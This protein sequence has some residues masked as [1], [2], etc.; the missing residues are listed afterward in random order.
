MVR[1]PNSM[2]RQLKGPAYCRREFIGGVPAVRISQFEHG[3][4]ADYPVKLVLHAKEQ[5]QIRHIALEAARISANRYLAK[6]VGNNNYFMKLL[7]YPHNVLREN[8]VAVGA[9]ADRISDG[10][11]H[12]FGKPV[13]TAARVMRKQALITLET[14]PSYFLQAKEALRRA[15]IKLPTPTYIEVIKGSEYAT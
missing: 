4:K 7:V 13:G 3:T 5:C 1:K 6:R 9:G 10:M 15:S 14:T 8:K 2:Y 12:A 11:R